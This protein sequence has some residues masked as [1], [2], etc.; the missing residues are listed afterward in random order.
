MAKLTVIYWR[1]IPS[2]VMAKQG[3]KTAKRQ[4]DPRFEAAIDH[5]AMRA[6]MTSTDDYIGEWRRGA[7][8][9]C[10]DD[11]EAVVA[12]AQTDLEAAFDEQRLKDLVANYGFE[13]S[14]EEATP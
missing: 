5:A 13:P 8:V 14:Q 1:D 9:D 4:L 6:K 12:A 7:A 3:R 11:L 10:G 2:T